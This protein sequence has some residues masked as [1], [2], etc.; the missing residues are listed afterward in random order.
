M[1]VTHATVLAQTDLTD[2]CGTDPSWICE[3]VLDA[4]GSTGLAEA[5]DVVF[6]TGG[7]ILLVLLVA[8]IAHFVIRRAIGRFVRRLVNS[9]N[10][11]FVKLRRQRGFLGLGRRPPEPVVIP[12]TVAGA[13][14]AARAE[15]L[16]QV[17]RSTATALVWTVAAVTILG[18]LGVNLG[19]LLASAGIAGVALGF[20]AQSLVKD[21]LSGFF[22]LV[23]DQFG[24]GDMVDLG[25]AVGHVEA[26]SLRVTRLRDLDGTVWH[27]PNGIIDRVG[28]MSQ[29][30]GRALLDVGVAYGTDL[31]L[32]Q[33][34]V[35]ETADGLWRDAEWGHTVLE[36]PEV[37]GV[38][39]LGVDAIAVRLVVKT[40]PGLQFP[41]KREL[42]QRL[43]AAFKENEIEIPFQQRTVWLR[44]ADTETSD[45]SE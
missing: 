21:F 14:A 27:I 16:T 5:S 44:H 33:R 43:W 37:W 29:E 8:A 18:E 24:V 17:L 7:R 26:V 23:E 6:G 32:A 35:K 10:E 28:N 38:E 20:G 40:K 22:L 45:T 3:R 41:V 42:R 9:S 36:E 13:R 39:Q 34:I 19:P 1:G 25:E 15:T 30:W 11:Q 4:S 12:A 2:A 31:D